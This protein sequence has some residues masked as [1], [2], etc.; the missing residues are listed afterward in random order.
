[1]GEM[2]LVKK[3]YVN[4]VNNAIKNNKI[5]HAYLFEIDDYD[6]DFSYILNFAK[7]IL[8]NCSY[9]QISE[10]DNPIFNMIDQNNYL[11]VCIIEPDGNN[12]K[13]IK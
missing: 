1:M 8:V 11:D 2:S 4:F 12:I 9:R 7:M 10:I 13:R 3:N 6:K 5:F